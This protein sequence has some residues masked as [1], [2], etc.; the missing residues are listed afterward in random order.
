[1][2]GFIGMKLEPYF[3]SWVSAKHIYT[4]EVQPYVTSNKPCWLG[5]ENPCFIV[6]QIW[7]NFFP[8]ENCYHWG[9]RGERKDKT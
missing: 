1:M 9:Q 7:V 5:E 2:I 8:Q 6:Q 3:Q 4:S